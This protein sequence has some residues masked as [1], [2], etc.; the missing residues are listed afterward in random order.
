[1]AQIA[2]C[3]QLFPKACLL[4]V[5]ILNTHVFHP[6]KSWPKRRRSWRWPRTNCTLPS[7]FFVVGS[8]RSLLWP[9]CFVDFLDFVFAEGPVFTIAKHPKWFFLYRWI[10]QAEMNERN[11]NSTEL[12]LLV[13]DIPNFVRKETKSKR[14]PKSIWDTEIFWQCFLW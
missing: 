11:R 13:L 1:M 2:K 4:S 5:I 9:F 12:L 7:F 10:I 6:E 14:E 3:C 8:G